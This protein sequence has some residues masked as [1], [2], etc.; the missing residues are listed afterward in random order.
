MGIHY[1]VRDEG[2]FVTCECDSCCASITR[3][4]SKYPEMNAPLWG[5]A[6]IA[7]EPLSECAMAVMHTQMMLCPRCIPLAAKVLASI[8]REN[9]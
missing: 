4:E 1:E 2:Q 8:R 5:M 9:R 7:L 6:G 3:P